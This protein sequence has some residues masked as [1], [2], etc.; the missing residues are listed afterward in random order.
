MGPS[1]GSYSLGSR[2]SAGLGMTEGSLGEYILE[3]RLLWVANGNAWNVTGIR[4][5]TIDQSRDKCGLE[6]F[7]ENLLF[8]NSLPGKVC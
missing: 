7:L 5:I 1:A 8:L 4:L 3:K 6:T 2:S